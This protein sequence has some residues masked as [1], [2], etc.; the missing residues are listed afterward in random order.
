MWY[1]A[2]DDGGGC[3]LF[4]VRLDAFGE[5]FYA[6][7]LQNSINSCCENIFKWLCAPIYC[8][9][10]HIQYSNV[11]TQSASSRREFEYILYCASASFAYCFN[12][13]DVFYFSLFLSD[14]SELVQ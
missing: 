10:I 14:A 7:A 5:I 8:L 13:D 1:V 6:K 12:P 4:C 3:R 9:C 2:D 11:H